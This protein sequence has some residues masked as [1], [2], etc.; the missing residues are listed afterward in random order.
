ME[1]IEKREELDKP[2]GT[3]NEEYGNIGLFLGSIAS[4][5]RNSLGDFDF[6]AANY[7][8]SSEN[9]LYW[10]IWLLCVLFTSIIFLNFIIAET[11]SSY[12]RIK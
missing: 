11:S 4:T 8:T 9:Y 12:E 1:E 10:F 6:E 7:L 3:P 5:F 2:D